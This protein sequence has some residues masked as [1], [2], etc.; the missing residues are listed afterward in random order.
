MTALQA[1][2]GPKFKSQ[3]PHGR[4]AQ[5]YKPVATPALRGKDRQIQEVYSPAS[6]AKQDSAS[7][8]KV[9][10]N[11]GRFLRMVSDSVYTHGHMDLNAPGK[12]L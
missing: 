11:Q 5:L 6:I 4:Q 10:G 12:H 9:E 3:H 7:K 1:T 8:N 2:I